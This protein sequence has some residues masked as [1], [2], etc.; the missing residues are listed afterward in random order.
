MTT[1]MTRGQASERVIDA[2]NSSV[3]MSCTSD[4]AAVVADVCFDGCEAEAGIACVLHDV[5]Q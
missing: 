5:D 2:M 4:V 3:P 1:T